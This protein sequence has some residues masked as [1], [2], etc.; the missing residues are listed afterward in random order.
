M[1]GKKREKSR[2]AQKVQK[3]GGREVEEE[4]NNARMKKRQE[5]GGQGV[6]VREGG[7]EGEGR[8]AERDEDESLIKSNKSRLV[9]K[10]I[11]KL[12]HEISFIQRP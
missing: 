11:I 10:A 7:G 8:E 6:G 1:R 9:P 2:W 5:R 3:G 4:K 12:T